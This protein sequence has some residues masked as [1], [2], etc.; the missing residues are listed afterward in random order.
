MIKTVNI[1][2]RKKCLRIF[3]QVNG[4]NNSQ[5]SGYGIMQEGI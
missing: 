1:M 3:L 4:Q 2:S 5:E